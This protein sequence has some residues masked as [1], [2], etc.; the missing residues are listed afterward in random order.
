MYLT[1][2]KP[3]TGGGLHEACQRRQT[4]V[5]RSGGVLRGVELGGGTPGSP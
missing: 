4:H 1:A 2:R 3:A 5:G